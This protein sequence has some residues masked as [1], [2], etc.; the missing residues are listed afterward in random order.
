MRTRS[1][2]REAL[3]ARW[4][5]LT[6]PERRHPGGTHALDLADALV[7]T[8]DPGDVRWAHE[9]LAARAKGE[10]RVSRAGT[11]QAHAA[12]SSTALVASAFAAWRRRA[13]ELPLA[14]LGPFGGLRLEE[15]LHIPHGGG[16]PNLDVA[17]D[18]P[19]GLVG[20]ESKLVEHLA[21]A[22][23]RPWR[24][25]YHRPAMAA[26][27]SGGWRTTFAALRDGS[28]APR[29]LD[30]GQMVRHA[31]SLRG[32]GDLVLL[33][34]EPADAEDHPD[35]L[36]HR[37]EVAELVE[38]VGDARPRLHALSWPAVLA[39]WAPVLPRHVAA[40]RQRYDVPIG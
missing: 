28:W 36:R 15:R 3:A 35:V 7:P 14:G 37:R 5:E 32:R 29:H 21:P 10:L 9:A 26:E 40:L 19:A 39:A 6:P 2:A 23:P 1:R 27:L 20:V 25:A 22:R 38:R 33:F 30:A 31:L 17:L 12:W 13:A 34:W 8:L 18:G 16:T 24:P 11:V 4:R